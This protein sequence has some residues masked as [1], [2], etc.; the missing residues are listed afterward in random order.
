[1]AKKFNAFLTVTIKVNMSIGVD[2]NSLEAA[3][4]IAKSTALARLKA[5]HRQLINAAYLVEPAITA[6]D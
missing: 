5:E 1:M 3:K 6:I 2:A 4:E